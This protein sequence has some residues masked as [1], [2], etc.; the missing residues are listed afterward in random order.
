M[1]WLNADSGASWRRTSARIG[2]NVGRG[3]KSFLHL[4]T[5]AFFGISPTIII[6]ATYITFAKTGTLNE[7]DV[8]SSFT[9]GCLLTD[10]TTVRRIIYGESQNRN[11]AVIDN[12]NTQ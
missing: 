3:G 1:V 7:I 6:D 10:N 9:G 12:S 4:A 8:T 2:H 5:Q 11:V